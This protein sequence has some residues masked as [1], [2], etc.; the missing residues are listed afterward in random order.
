MNELSIQISGLSLSLFLSLCVCLLF[1]IYYPSGRNRSDVIHT[2][3]THLPCSR[4]ANWTCLDSTLLLP[5]Y[6]EH[7]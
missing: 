2:V 4:D 7:N 1:A 5:V 3:V 6:K